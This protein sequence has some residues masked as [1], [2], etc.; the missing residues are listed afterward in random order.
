TC[1]LVGETFQPRVTAGDTI[2]RGQILLTFDPQEM[3]RKGF[4]TTTPVVVTNPENFGDIVFELG[5]RKI[6]AQRAAR[7][8]F[9]IGGLAHGKFI[10]AT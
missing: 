10:A 2:R 5:R 7:E 1:K 3:I 6:F 9:L 8:D 4:D